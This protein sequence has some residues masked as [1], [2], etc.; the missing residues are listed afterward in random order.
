[1]A[2]KQ[3]Q[4]AATEPQH[5]SS[6]CGVPSTSR[7]MY[8]ARDCQAESDIPTLTLYVDVGQE[9]A[10]LTWQPLRLQRPAATIQTSFAVAMPNRTATSRCNK[11]LN[12]SLH[13]STVCSTCS[14][15]PPVLACPLLTR[16]LH[17]QFL[18]SACRRKG[19]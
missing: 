19:L 14:S 18:C 1:M 16:S 11:T 7:R 10:M 3:A 4:P 15:A 9:Q 13:I 17:H 8:T 5:I 12:L 2:F 6:S